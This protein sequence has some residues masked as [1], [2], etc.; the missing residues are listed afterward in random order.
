M[1]KSKLESYSDKLLFKM[2]SLINNECK[3]E[4]IIPRLS[5]FDEQIYE[6]TENA[7]KP[8]GIDVDSVD[9][10]F[11][12][13]LLKINYDNIDD[14]VLTTLKRPEISSYSYDIDVSE[15]LFQTTTY[16][17]VIHTY[18][19]KPYDYVK[20]FENEGVI[21]PWGGKEIYT[22]IH[23]SESS[24]YDIDKRSFTKI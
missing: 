3:E 16:Q 14:G 1:E 22:N 23:D 19:S 4:R 7:L 6:I 24:G 9:V 21:D 2:L 8:F 20:Y 13:E 15:T 10:D 5:K 12:W 18:S 17:H 11:M